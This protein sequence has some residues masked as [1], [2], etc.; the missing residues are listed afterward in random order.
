MP[1]SVALA[2]SI[3]IVRPLAAARIV[4]QRR[5]A[6]T[7][8]MSSTSDQITRCASTSIAGTVASRRK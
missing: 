4:R 6:V 3:A 2:A 5:I 1:I 7:T 8:T